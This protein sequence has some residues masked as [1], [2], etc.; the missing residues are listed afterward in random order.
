LIPLKQEAMINYMAGEGRL[1]SPGL[2][3]KKKIRKLL[4]VLIYFKFMICSRAQGRE[5]DYSKM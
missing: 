5:G 3:W 4:C 2:G 1:S